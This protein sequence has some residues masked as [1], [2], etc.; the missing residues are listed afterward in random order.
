[1]AA[2]SPLVSVTIVP[3]SELLTDLNKDREAHP[4]A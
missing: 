1:V 3:R 4:E 2:P